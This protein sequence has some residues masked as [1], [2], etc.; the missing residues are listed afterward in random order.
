MEQMEGSIRSTS[1][2]RT[3]HRSG[4]PTATPTGSQIDPRTAKTPGH[5]VRPRDTAASSRASN[6]RRSRSRKLRNKRQKKRYSR[7]KSRRSRRHSISM[8]SNEESEA[9][10]EK[11]DSA[12]SA[13]TPLGMT[14]VASRGVTAAPSLA[15]NWKL[16]R[17]LA[18]D[19]G[20]ARQS[21]EC[22]TFFRTP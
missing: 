20:A 11:P 17:Q 2:R 1:P 7:R 6:K 19:A 4:Q 8:A 9:T 14:N 18:G 10:A 13:S 5:A 3:P 21:Q 22:R 15:E 16:R 12:V